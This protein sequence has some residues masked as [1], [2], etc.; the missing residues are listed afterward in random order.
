MLKKLQRCFLWD[1][2]AV[3]KKSHLV[4]WETVCTDKSQGGLGL[5]KLHILNKALLGKSIWNLP[6][7]QIPCGSN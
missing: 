2:G 7:I 5:K 1:G 4:N 6:Q 3:E